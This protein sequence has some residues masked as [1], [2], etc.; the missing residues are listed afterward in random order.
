MLRAISSA[1]GFDLSS[2]S[3]DADQAIA[4]K[5]PLDVPTNDTTMSA[6][7]DDGTVSQVVSASDVISH[8]DVSPQGEVIALRINPES[9]PSNASFVEAN[10]E[11]TIES[12][13]QIQ[14]LA[15]RL[16]ENEKALESRKEKFEQRMSDWQATFVEKVADQQKQ[17]ELRMSQLQ[18]QASNVRCQQLHLVQLQTDIVKSHEA[19]RK[20]IEGLITDPGADAKMIQTLEN[21]KYQLSGRFDF[22][23]RRWEH[24]AELMKNTRVE[25]MARGATDDHVDWTEEAA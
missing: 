22:I 18:Q 15:E 11:N 10:L 4:P 12:A 2:E 7:T 13:S 14:Q 21:L 25:L 8:V 24:L 20:A 1:N 6:P 23:A 17:F 3:F 16:R 9:H 19:A 5:A